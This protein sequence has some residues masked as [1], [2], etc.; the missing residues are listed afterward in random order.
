VKLKRYSIGLILLLL[1]PIIG[2]FFDAQFLGLAEIAAVV[3]LL[4]L[5]H[6]VRVINKDADINILKGI[7]VYFSVGFYEVWMSFI[8]ILVRMKNLVGRAFL[9]V[10]GVVWVVA[11][12]VLVVVLVVAVVGGLIGVLVFGWRQLI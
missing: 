2:A 12:V 11:V 6:T 4:S 3:F 10:V 5:Y 8:G 9:W 1:M 7:F